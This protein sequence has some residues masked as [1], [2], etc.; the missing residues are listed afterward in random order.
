[1]LAERTTTLGT[2]W[3]E[4]STTA[5]R[6]SKMSWKAA[7]PCSFQHECYRPGGCR[8]ARV[9]I[10]KHRPLLR[11]R[12]TTGFVLPEQAISQSRDDPVSEVPNRPG[13]DP[14]QSAKNLPSTAKR[15]QN[16][17][18]R[19]RSGKNFAVPHKHQRVQLVS[20]LFSYECPCS[21]SLQRRKSQL[22]LRI[23][24]QQPVD[25]VVAEPAHT[26]KENYRMTVKG[27]SDISFG[28]H[29]IHSS[30]A[31]R[32]LFRNRRPELIITVNICWPEI[33]Q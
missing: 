16:P 11:R 4:S 21:R 20:N 7:L 9:S 1:M 23:V 18:D 28:R 26:I 29:R 15:H 8:Q 10:Q 22:M 13:N 14:D 3:K 32:G 2:N 27:C 6:R 5:Y 33:T 31:C 24:S 30:I 25:G 19:C 17:A 12:Q